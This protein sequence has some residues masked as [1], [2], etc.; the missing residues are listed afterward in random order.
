M[1]VDPELRTCTSSMPTVMLSSDSILLIFIRYLQ[2]MKFIPWSSPKSI[3]EKLIE[4]PKHN[5]IDSSSQITFKSNR[6]KNKHEKLSTKPGLCGLINIGNTCFMNSAIQCL[7]N[8]PQLTEWAKKQQ[9]SNHEATVTQAYTS[10]IKSIWSGENASFTPYDIK[11]RV[12]QHAPI[13]SDYAQKDS[14]EFM[15]SLLNALHSEFIENDLSKEQSSIVTNLF[16]ITTQSRVTCLHCDMSDS[17]EEIT[18]C[19]PLS[20]ENESTV[21]LQTLLN[22]FLKEEQLDGQYYC[23]NCQD[24]QSAKQK[25]SLCQPLPPVIIVQLK[26]F[27]YDET[28]NKLNTLVEY[29]IDNWNVDG[30]D[31]A[32]YDLVAVS[33][34]VGHLQGGHYTTFAC[35]NGLG[36]WYHFNDSN[37]EP[38]HDTDCL[39]NRNAYVLLYLKKN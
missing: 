31:N 7:S 21:T 4:I 1:D 34:H 29:P 14:H 9:L 27:T 3:C 35:L 6:S 30:S 24:F 38:I 19:L 10:L 11:N 17:L 23:S 8:I 18:Y 20:L 26:R 28:N 16:A 36:P 2:L 15:N 25:T 13:F 33:M 5:E 22:D 37:I 12:S 32:L 39:V